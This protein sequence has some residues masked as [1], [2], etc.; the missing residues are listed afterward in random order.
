M[1]PISEVSKLLG[2]ENETFIKR[3]IAESII[4]R[5][6]DD[7]ECFGEYLINPDIIVELVEESIEECKAEVKEII[8]QKIMNETLK[9]LEN[10]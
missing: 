2:A 9:K 7:L 10:I 5:F 3:S 8:K 1:N 4:E 6:K